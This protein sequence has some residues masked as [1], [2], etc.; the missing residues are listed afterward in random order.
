[1]GESPIKNPTTRASLL[2]HV[3][4][5]LFR[6][7]RKT[8][9]SSLQAAQGLLMDLIVLWTRSGA[10]ACGVSGTN[11]RKRVGAFLSSGRRKLRRAAPV[12]IGT[13]QPLGK[14]KLLD[15]DGSS[16][17][18]SG[19]SGWRHPRCGAWGRLQR[20]G[21]TA[22][23]AAQALCLHTDTPLTKTWCW[24]LSFHTPGWKQPRLGGSKPAQML[25]SGRAHFFSEPWEDHQS[26]FS[27]TCLL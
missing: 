14:A 1:M 24:A 23:T 5:P 2:L 17:G 15:C 11:F 21:S 7:M 26:P 4:I 10:A 6:A 8:R 22:R 25:A 18:G 20:R 9:G 3:N 19:G 27:C 12:A 16:I 13:H